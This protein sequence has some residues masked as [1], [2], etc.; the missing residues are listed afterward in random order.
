[1]LCGNF[2]ESVT[3]RNE[4]ALEVAEMK[5]PPIARRISV[6]DLNAPRARVVLEPPIFLPCRIGSRILYIPLSNWKHPM[7][8]VATI[9]S[10]THT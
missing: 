4:P 8:V 6:S 7:I 10:H 3:G 2:A 1:M 9:Q 5:M